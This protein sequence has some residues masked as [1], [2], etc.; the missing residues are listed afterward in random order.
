MKV[1][2]KT[3]YILDEKDKKQIKKQMIDL[4]LTLSKMAKNIGV[5]KSYISEIISGK[6]HLT[7][8]IIEQ[9]KSQG[10]TIKKED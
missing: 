5:S 9:F 10:I 7:D 6:K 8:K 1:I 3:Y 2:T 4:D